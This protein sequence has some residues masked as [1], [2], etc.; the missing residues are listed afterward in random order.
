MNPTLNPS[1]QVSD[2]YQWRFLISL[3]KPIHFNRWAN[4]RYITALEF[5][6]ILSRYQPIPNEFLSKVVEELQIVLHGINRQTSFQDIADRA[7]IQSV[8]ELCPHV[9]SEKDAKEK[10]LVQAHELLDCLEIINRGMI[11]MPEE[12]KSCFS[13]EQGTFK[14]NLWQFEFLIHWIKQE[15]N[16]KIPDELIE[17]DKEFELQK[18]LNN[19]IYKNNLREIFGKDQI[20]NDGLI[21]VRKIMS[22]KLVLA[23]ENYV[24]N[25]HEKEIN[26]IPS[27]SAVEADLVD[28]YKNYGVTETIARN[29]NEC[30]RH[31]AK[32]KIPLGNVRKKTIFFQ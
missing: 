25:M 27:S 4:R 30:S 8:N 2:S 6:F 14:E 18:E 12:Y 26:T 13:L 16:I 29:I 19:K 31:D 5:G 3:L 21:D 20:M 22:T 23:L 32:A 17:L 15:S 1:L 10:I 7:F 11:T 24:L 9:A 28:K